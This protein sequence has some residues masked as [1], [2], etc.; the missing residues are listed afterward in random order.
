MTPTCIRALY[1]IPENKVAD[2]SNS[3][4]FYEQGV[5]YSQQN[6]DMFFR[7]LAPWVPEGTAPVQQLIDGAEDPVAPNA[8]MSG[9]EANID[10]QVAFGLVY[11]TVPTIY[12][13]DD[14]PYEKEESRV[15][16]LFNT[17]LDAVSRSGHIDTT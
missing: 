8:S 17:L 16:A 1:S 3:P 15:D 2:P 14:T 5:W 11:P 6:L 9:T 12:Q 10:L 7:H 4:G 13:V